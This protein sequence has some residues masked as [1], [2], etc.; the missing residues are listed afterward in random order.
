[1][2]TRSATLAASLT[3]LLLAVAAVASGCGS[4]S[5]S[6][7]GVAAL[8]DSETTTTEDEST[9]TTA[10]D[11]PQETALKWAKCMREHGVDVP[12]PEVSEDGGRFTVRAGS[13]G[14]RLDRVDGTKFREAQKACGTPFGDSGPPPISAEEREKLQEA[15]L[16]F[17]KC[18]REHGVD[19]PDPQFSGDGGGG[20]LFRAGRGRGAVNPDSP[21]FREAEKA[22]GDILQKALPDGRGP[23]RV[24]RSDGS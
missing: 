22:C 15:M 21:R 4:T 6:D 7:D 17:A 2:K 1:M 14:R 20:L 10:D 5:A 11:D 13:R 12:D 18:M 8:D 9:A 3:A 24:Q 23:G 16:A 19:M